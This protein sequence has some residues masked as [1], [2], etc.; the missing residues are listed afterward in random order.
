MTLA[1]FVLACQRA[2]RDSVLNQT[3]HKR[4]SGAET[5]VLTSETQSVSDL[6]REGGHSAFEQCRQAFDDLSCDLKPEAIARKINSIECVS[7]FEG[8]EVDQF[9]MSAFQLDCDRVSARR[10]ARELLLRKK[11]ESSILKALVIDLERA[12][13]DDSLRET[14]DLFL[15]SDNK[16]AIALLEHVT[17]TNL[18]T[19]SDDIS[20]TI[21]ALR[22]SPNCTFRYQNQSKQTNSC[23]YLCAGPQK[24]HAANKPQCNPTVA[25]PANS[26][27]QIKRVPL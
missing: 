1:Q 27:L 16:E 4:L 23:H 11:N 19:G 12:Q 10:A 5:D 24:F 8:G 14:L 21:E 2:Q 26:D 22:A 6:A 20:M 3:L 13:D 7:V 25:R 9:L 15:F 17:S 18:T